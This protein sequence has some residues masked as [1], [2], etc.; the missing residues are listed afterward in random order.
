MSATIT[1]PV[2]LVMGI[3]G[4]IALV[5]IR[6]QIGPINF[7]SGLKEY[8]DYDAQKAL[9]ARVAAE[10]KAREAA[11]KRAEADEKA[12]EEAKQREMRDRHGQ[13]TEFGEVYYVF[14]KLLVTKRGQLPGLDDEGSD[15]IQKMDIASCPGKPAWIG[16]NPPNRFSARLREDGVLYFC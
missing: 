7:N 10:D 8:T 1:I 6:P 13:K 4:G 15:C 5:Q 2:T 16:L 11:L 3:V 14:C 9:A 12:T